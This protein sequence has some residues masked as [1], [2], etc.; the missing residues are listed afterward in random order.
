MNAKL[1]NNLGFYSVKAYTTNS[2][3]SSSTESRSWIFSWSY[4]SCLYSKMFWSGD[5]CVC[6]YVSVSIYLYLYNYSYTHTDTYQ[7]YI[8]HIIT[9]ISCIYIYVC[10]LHIHICIYT[11]TYIYERERETIKIEIR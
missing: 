3:L 10:V 9:Y 6:I 7:S 2:C 8:C 5:V 11:Y 4:L 1:Y